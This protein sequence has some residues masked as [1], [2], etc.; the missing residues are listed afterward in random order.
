MNALEPDDIL[1]LICHP[2]VETWI[3]LREW[4]R[5]GSG[6]RKTIRPIAAKNAQTDEPLPLSAIPLAVRN[7]PES[8]EAIR[9]GW[10]Q[11]PE[12]PNEYY[13]AKIDRVDREEGT[14]CVTTAAQKRT[15]VIADD[16][17]MLIFHGDEYYPM[18]DRL[19][20][21]HLL[22][23]ATVIVMSRRKEG[24]EIVFQLQ[25]VAGEDQGAGQRVAA[26]SP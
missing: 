3:P 14:I 13:S 22:P 16:T 5:R 19:H 1:V 15:V 18:K 20:D 25:L 8:W 4:M 17:E 12:W 24:T 26:R 10:I 21:D 2:H 23:G 9:L 11:D 7:D 6:P